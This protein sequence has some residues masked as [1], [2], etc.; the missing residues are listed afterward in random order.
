MESAYISVVFGRCFLLATV[1]DTGKISTLH[2][3]PK[4]HDATDGISIIL[5]RDFWALHHFPRL[6][7]RINQAAIAA[8]ATS[9]I[10]T[11]NAARVL[12]A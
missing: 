6:F 10:S 7:S 1:S 3:K 12:F 8:P 11:P 5:D 9:P 2:I 4:A